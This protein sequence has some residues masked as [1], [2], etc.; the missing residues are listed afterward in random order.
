MLGKMPSGGAPYALVVCCAMMPWFF[1][2]TAMSESGNSLVANSNL[3]SKIYFPRLIMPA[4]SVITSFVDFLISAAILFGIMA[5]YHYAPSIHILALPVFILIAFAA[6]LSVGIWIAALTVEYRDFRV[7]VPFVLQFGLYVT[8][9]GYLSSAVGQKLGDTWRIL[10]S[11]NP[12][13][14]VIDGFR[15][16]ILGGANEFYWP[17]LALSAGISIILLIS[18]IWYFRKTEKSFADVI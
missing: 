2:S 4:S 12:M 15:W 7:I 3:I 17:S 11:I 6:S 10:Y 8:P 9:V 5:W 16:S 1:F 13:V 14:G 18:G